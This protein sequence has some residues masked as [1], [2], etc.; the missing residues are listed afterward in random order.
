LC[1]GHDRSNRSSFFPDITAELEC[2]ERIGESSASATPNAKKAFTRI[3]D[4]A[5]NVRQQVGP[6]KFGTN[7][8][9]LTWKVHSMKLSNVKTWVNEMESDVHRLETSKS[10]LPAWQKQLLSNV[11]EDTHELVYQTSA[12]IK[13]L[14][15]HHNKM[16]L[17]TTSYPQDIDMI[18]QKANDAANS[19]GTVFQRHGID[20]D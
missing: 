9:D 17:V 3:Q 1:S 18:S 8:T 20:I 12:A 6:L 5:Q 13:V 11:R 15:Q 2:L 19:I 4:L 16:A 10:D 14:D 7:G